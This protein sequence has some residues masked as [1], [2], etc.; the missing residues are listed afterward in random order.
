M[1]K[2]DFDYPDYASLNCSSAR[3]C[4]IKLRYPE[5]HKHLNT[6]YGHLS[7]FSER[8]HWFY[9]GLTEHP[10][11]PVCGKPSRF[12]NFKTGYSTCC[13]GCY[14]KSAERK[15]SLRESLLAKYG[16]T[17]V[18]QLKE[19]KDKTRQTCIARYGVSNAAQSDAARRAISSKRGSD[20]SVCR[21]RQTCLERYG[22]ENP[23]Q[24]SMFKQKQRDACEVSYG[25]PFPSQTEH[26]KQLMRETCLGR[27]GCEHVF[28]SDAVRSKILTTLQER[29]GTGNP[30]QSECLKSRHDTSLEMHY[31][32]TNP[33]QCEEIKQRMHQTC[34]ERYGFENP[35]QSSEIRDK[36]YETKRKNRT[37]N[38]SKIEEE[39]SKYLTSKGLEHIRQYKSDVY[40]FACDF[41]IPKYDLYVEIQGS[42]THG[43]HPFDVSDA[44]DVALAEAWRSS[45]SKYYRNAARVWCE[46][47]VHKRSVAKACGLNYLEL[48]TT[49]IDAAVKAFENHLPV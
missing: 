45:E 47:D 18:A 35:M 40:P 41:Y 27:Y 7:S 16:V 20:E 44:S 11:C 29:Y 34:L 42:W 24:L 1:S 33:M 14:N 17:N 25:T 37:F 15:K 46:A 19:V 21:A 9:N 8:L 13:K 49:K 30:M 26:V 39:F 5:F 10:V 32:V 38:T 48:F 28:Q 43:N 3:E 4:S 23:M 31:G 12:Y 6:A 36:S 22:V 2:Y